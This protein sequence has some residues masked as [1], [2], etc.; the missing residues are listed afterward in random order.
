M[1]KVNK[2]SDE[3]WENLYSE[4][5]RASDSIESDSV[6]GTFGEKYSSKNL[7]PGFRRI[8]K[9]KRLEGDSSWEELYD[10]FYPGKI[11]RRI[12]L[13]HYPKKQ[14]IDWIL[15]ITQY[16]NDS[17]KQYI[18]STLEEGGNDK[19]FQAILS[20][21]ITTRMDKLDLRWQEHRDNIH[22]K[23]NKPGITVMA[24]SYYFFGLTALAGYSYFTGLP[25]IPFSLSVVGI[26]VLIYIFL[27]YQGVKDNILDGLDS[28]EHLIQETENEVMNLIPKDLLNIIFNEGYIESFNKIVINGKPLTPDVDDN[29]PTGMA[30]KGLMKE[31]QEMDLTR[32]VDFA[33][34]GLMQWMDNTHHLYLPGETSRLYRFIYNKVRGEREFVDYESVKNPQVD[35][36]RDGLYFPS[37]R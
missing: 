12:N 14:L 36:Y 33:V 3:Q 10:K 9:R 5:S 18:Q 31:A 19:F 34:T 27:R 4:L 2:Y 32:N 35:N 8:A 13:T 17:D 11:N 16:G 37:K 28:E 6:F 1:P 25:N 26:T 29:S 23:W 22:T 21:M 7:K 15:Q 24:M 20:E 30:L